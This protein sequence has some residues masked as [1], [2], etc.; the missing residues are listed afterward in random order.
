MRTYSTIIDPQ[1]AWSIRCRMDDS[2]SAPRNLRGA[3]D[4]VRRLGA[5][6]NLEPTQ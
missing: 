5:T 4:V 1:S 3:A 2:P 6:R